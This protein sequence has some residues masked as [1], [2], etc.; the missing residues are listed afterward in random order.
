MGE[1]PPSG[2][3]EAGRVPEGLPLAR[4]EGLGEG[5]REGGAGEGEGVALPPPPPPPPP[6]AGEGLPAGEPLGLALPEALCAS[7]ALAP[8]EALAPSVCEPL[9]EGVEEGEGGAGE[10]VALASEALAAEEPLGLAWS[11]AP[12]VGEALPGASEGEGEP[13][14]VAAAAAL[15]AA[16]GEAVPANC[17]SVGVGRGL[18]EAEAMAVAVVLV[19][20]I[21]RDRRSSSRQR[22][23]GR[24]CGILLLR[25]LGGSVGAQ[26]SCK[27][28]PGW[29]ALAGSGGSSSRERRELA[30]RGSR[31]R[32]LGCSAQSAEC[33]KQK[34]TYL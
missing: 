20:V 31:H 33:N 4:S 18:A 32:V 13:E 6:P 11:E 3:A 25:P 9:A 28:S 8:S 15:A 12:G 24:R 26:C 17:S 30:A 19:H 10:G 34:T 27:K 16:L 1:L 29:R 22:P 5:V 21:G 7:V 2:E 23:R 14:G